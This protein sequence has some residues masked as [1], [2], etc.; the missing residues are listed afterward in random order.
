MSFFSKTKAVLWPKSATTDLYLDR[1]EN[2]V[3]SVDID[4]WKTCTSTE[5]QSLVL[6]LG[7]NKV[8]ICT[9][10]IPD[11]VVV[12]KS[13]IYDSE[14]TS[15][16]K[17]EVIGL[18]ESTVHFKIHPD[19]LDYRLIPTS[20]KT[21]IL[22]HIFDKSKIESLKTNLDL[23]KLKSFAFE[24][25]SQSISKVISLRFPG[26]Y[27]LIYPLSKSEYTLSL[28]KKDSVYLTAN[29]K[30]PELDVQKIIN[31]S[32]LY[33][34]TLTTKFYV[35][36][37]EDLEIN[38]TSTLEKTPYSPSQIAQ[39]FKKAANLPLPVIGLM[40]SSDAIP[41]IITQASDT[42]LS[43]RNMEKNHNILP[44]IGVFVAT[45]VIASA[46][47]W[48]VLS[49]NNSTTVENPLAN[50]VTPTA[51]VESPTA[52][53]IP[54]VAEISKKLKIQ[55][56]NGTSINGQA[57]VL[58]EKLTNLGFTNVTVGNSKESATVNSIQ[59]KASLSTASAY[60]QQKLAGFFDA[61]PTA[62]LKASSTYDAV[63]IIGTNLSGGAITATPTPLK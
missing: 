45:A 40:I 23:L 34:P 42:S 12:T 51:V 14:I 32:N 62:D 31:Y 3:F 22:A 43:T 38:A 54:S 41:A 46:I 61:V 35:P 8:D 37:D 25:V 4:L 5:I 27:F 57:A 49:K 60:F 21:T 11:D 28:S 10:L 52:T 48:F 55:V 17:A 47:I 18:A 7:Q 36:A 33:F 6:L 1:V 20:G 44:F 39:E 16:E 19:Y 24:S 13:F 58:K 56:L 59:I 2:N 15:I 63:F 53:P 9:I 50:S 26:E 29:L 30:G